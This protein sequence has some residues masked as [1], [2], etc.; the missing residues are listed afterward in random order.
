MNNILIVSA[1]YPPE[2]I[3]TSLISEALAEILCSDGNYVTVLCP[4]PSRGL[5]I[6]DINVIPK[7]KYENLEVIRLKSY[8]SPKS[9]IISRFFESLSFGLCAF[10]FI[11]KLK[12]KPAILYMNIWPI[13]SQLLISFSCIIL[14]IPYINHIQDV[15]PESLIYRLPN[16]SKNI[17]HKTFFNIDNYISKNATGL[18]FIS[19]KIYINYTLTRNINNVSAKVIHNWTD[20]SKYAYIP[21][22]NDVCD[23]YNIKKDLVTFMF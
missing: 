22:R 13:F 21:N 17:I 12:K 18:I 15:Y 3:V 23:Y 19:N 8:R 7:I 9:K 10:Y 20:E 4:Y 11:F 6:K 16:I 2:P 1:A 5:N 14:N